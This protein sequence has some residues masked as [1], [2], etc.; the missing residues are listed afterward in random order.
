MDE[1]KRENLKWCYLYNFDSIE[2]GW[3]S[4]SNA[5]KYGYS[6]TNWAYSPEV[7]SKYYV[8]SNWKVKPQW[9]KNVRLFID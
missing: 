2:Q 9:V 4:L 6:N 3:S 5:I 7:I 1:E 8:G